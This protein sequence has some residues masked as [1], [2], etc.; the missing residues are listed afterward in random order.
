MTEEK[1]PIK[2]VVVKRVKKAYTLPMG[3]KYLARNGELKPRHENTIEQ[4]TIFKVFGGWYVRGYIEGLGRQ[5]EPIQYHHAD[6]EHKLEQDFDKMYKTLFS[7][8]EDLEVKPEPVRQR[9]PKVR[10][11]QDSWG[12]TG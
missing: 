1:K 4:W 10:R 11:S 7:E 8:P 5:T 6:P 2:K 3:H 12:P 9:S